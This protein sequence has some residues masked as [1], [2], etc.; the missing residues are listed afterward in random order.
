MAF[1]DKR[2]PIRINENGSRSLVIFTRNND[3]K[4]LKY[5]T[6]TDRAA[7]QALSQ[8]HNTLY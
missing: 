6:N 2:L 1:W 7:Q 3:K 8:P 5:L 4:D